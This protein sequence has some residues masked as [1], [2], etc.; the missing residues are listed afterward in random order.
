MA[1]T[2]E[3]I[4]STTV[5]SPTSSISFSSI[6]SAYTDLQI[7]G[8]V[9]L[10]SSGVGSELYMRF[11]S[12]SGTEYSRTVMSSN[13]SSVTGTQNSGATYI[14]LNYVCDPITTAF[15][16]VFIYIPNYTATATVHRVL[17]MLSRG[18]T[19]PLG[20]D[21]LAG[22]YHTNGAAISTITFTLEGGNNFASGCIW[23]LYGILKA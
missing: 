6:S 21:Y 11:N 7:I 14:R 23:T 8:S 5:S 12:N 13:G 18:S 3:K 19:S 9:K 22:T 15:T 1:K 2:Y 17:S 10:Q 16:D 4:A 20:I